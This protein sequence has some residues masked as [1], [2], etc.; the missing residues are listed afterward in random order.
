MRGTIQGYPQKSEYLLVVISRACGIVGIIV[1]NSVTLVIYVISCL[2]EVLLKL[3]E[4]P[5]ANQKNKVKTKQ[6]T[7]QLFTRNRNTVPLH[8]CREKN[9]KAFIRALPITFKSTSSLTQ[10]LNIKYWSQQQG[11]CPPFKTLPPTPKL[12]TFLTSRIQGKL[13]NMQSN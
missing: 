8:Q 3:L 6:H 10:S 4:V 12:L 1:S 9:R 7:I 13:V 5:H 2:V 11:F